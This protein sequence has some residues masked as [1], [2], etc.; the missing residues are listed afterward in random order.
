MS[1]LLL[2]RMHEA[3]L[4]I[5]MISI[6]CY[7]L[8][9]VQKSNRIKQIGYI[10]LWLVFVLQTGSILLFRV[11]VG[12]M[13]F[14]TLTEG[15]YFYTWLII[16][17]SIILSRFIKTEFFVFM[18]NLIGFIF[19][20]I[21]TFHPAEFYQDTTVSHMM[22]E[23][24]WIHVT[25]AIISYVMFLV[26]SL[27]AVLYIVQMNYLKKKKFNQKFF[28]ISDLSSL[29]QLAFLFAIIGSVFLLISLILGIYWGLSFE[30]NAIWYDSK[31]IG[32]LIL[33]TGYFIY[34][35]LHQQ[36]RL[37]MRLLMDI[38]LMLFL[39]LLINYLVASRFS[40]FHQ[41]FY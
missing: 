30:G 28:R 18:M 32:S 15:F 20:M 34:I 19:M 25:L 4:I 31:V 41:L 23:L 6:A 38:N 29:S 1:E 17:L 22:N 11:V 35:Y 9:F 3:I 12:R 16:L 24:L 39:M 40:G 14:E 26:S 13:P 10:L 8:D 27:H 33:L 2:M 37:Q 21:H 5:Y 36:M 7:F